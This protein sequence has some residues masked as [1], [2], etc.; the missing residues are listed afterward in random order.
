MEEKE[1]IRWKGNFKKTAQ[2]IVIVSLALTIGCFLFFKLYGARYDYLKEKCEDLKSSSENKFKDWLDA[3]KSRQKITREKY[4]KENEKYQK[5]KEKYEKFREDFNDDI[6]LIATFVFAGISGATILFYFYVSKME[7]T[8]TNT[9]VYG[10]KAFG[11]RV[12]LP[13]DTISAVGTS[14]LQGIDIG[15]SAGKIHFKGI[16]NNNEIHAEISKLLN[17]RQSNKKI[18]N[19]GQ[20]K[21]NNISITEELKK[22]KELLDSGIITQEEFDS[23]KK[24]LLNL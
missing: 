2:I 22:Y 17:N 9:R 10:I 4:D 7:I 19:Q 12:D 15:T 13:L 1:I 11:K 23:K 16:S 6:Y 5:A 21:E 20:V 18:D 3:D 24:Q 8:V 14:F